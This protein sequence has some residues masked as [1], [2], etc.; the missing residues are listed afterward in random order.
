MYTRAQELEVNWFVQIRAAAKRHTDVTSRGR[1]SNLS[2]GSKHAS[3][4]LQP[5]Q[6]H[7]EQRMSLSLNPHFR[8]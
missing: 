3:G 6:T 2:S 7:A 4:I 1:L 5:G 8:V